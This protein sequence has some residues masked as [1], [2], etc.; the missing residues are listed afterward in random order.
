M[1]RGRK[2]QAGNLSL[3]Q[4]N[5]D[6]SIQPFKQQIDHHAIAAAT[7][8]PRVHCTLFSPDGQYVLAADLGLDKV[9]SYPFSPTSDKP[10][11][12]NKALV[13]DTPKGYGPRHL[14][15]HPKGKYLYMIA[16]KSGHL[17]SYRYKAGTLKQM[18][19][20]LSDTT[21][22]DGKG[23]SADIHI[24]PNG[25][26]LYVS[27]RQKA[28]E[29]VGYKITASGK[30]KEVSRHS[31][32]GIHPRNF[33]IDPTGSF[34]LVGNVDTGNIAVLKIDQRSGKLSPTGSGVKVEKPFCLKMIE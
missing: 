12:A 24:T 32:M 25:K 10:L 13:Y 20:Q 9:F 33:V 14:A 7:E 26:F 8:V 1:G 31:S 16:E 11:S 23:A 18:Q 17:L 29:L 22:Q 28:N 5:A 4:T 6:G 21:N 3:F 34:L 2:L 19:D 27:H 30:L 15:M